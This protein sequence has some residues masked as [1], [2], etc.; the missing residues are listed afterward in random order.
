VEG[1]FCSD[2]S[3]ALRNLPLT[4]I[5]RVEVLDQRS[6]KRPITGF[7]AWNLTKPQHLLREDRKWTIW[8]VYGGYGKDD[9]TQ[10]GGK[11]STF[12][13]TSG[14]NSGPFHNINSKNFKQD[15]QA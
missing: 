6:D 8:R 4:P 12:K 7:D 1:V 13:E 10:A 14:F 11:V 2:P 15:S 9:A 5:E 3:I